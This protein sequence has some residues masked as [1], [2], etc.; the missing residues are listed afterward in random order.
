MTA[1]APSSSA[2][3]S[4]RAKASA[5]VVSQSSS[6]SVMLPPTIVWSAPPIVPTIERD[7]TVIPRT[8]PRDR[9]TR[10]PSRA[11]LVVVMA[12][13]MGG[14]SPFALGRLEV[15]HVADPDPSSL[16]L[17]VELDPRAHELQ[18]PDGSRRR[19]LLAPRLDLH[20]HP[21]ERSIGRH[22][23]DR[24][25]LVG[26]SRKTGR[27]QVGTQALAPRVPVRPRDLAATGDDVI[28][29]L[30]PEEE[31]DVALSMRAHHLFVKREE[32]LRVG[33]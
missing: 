23:H 24:R 2:W 18:R 14:L 12:G 28:V 11:G 13:F 26:V 31:L 30:G 15:R 6:K 17:L 22:P 8:T 1:F 9:V 21:A 7:R 5:R 25:N 10:K 4:I 29:P 33:W 32:L 3:R 27:L 20:D 16:L 19:R